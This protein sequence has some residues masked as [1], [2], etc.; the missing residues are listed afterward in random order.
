MWTREFPLIEYQIWG[1]S[2]KNFLGENIGLP[3]RTIFILQDGLGEIYRNPLLSN[4]VNAVILKKVKSDPNFI[5]EFYLENMLLLEKLEKTWLNQDC[6]REELLLFIDNLFQF[7]PAIYAAIF[8]PLDNSFTDEQRNLFLEFRKR[9]EPVE[10]EAHHFINRSIQKLYPEVGDLA[11]I[12]SLEDLEDDNI[13]REKLEKRISNRIIIVDDEIVSEEKFEKLKKLGGYDLEESKEYFS[14]KK[15]IGQTAYHGKV[16][17]IVQIVRRESDI[18]KVEVGN[19]MVCQ[20]TLPTYIS[21]MK[22]A[23]AFVTD[24]GGITCHAAIV[25]REMKK[26]CIIGTKNATKI[27]KDGDL[28]EVDADKGIVRKI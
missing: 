14:A 6:S 18:K 27:L 24:E 21:A 20:M 26:P 12:V 1:R 23:A 22:K 25:A 8:I 2:Y 19:I 11:W 17:G 15:V 3:A 9:I 28:V 16:R 7:W 5:E 13:S 4:L 10:H